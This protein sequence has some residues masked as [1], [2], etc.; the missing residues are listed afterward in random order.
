M[1]HSHYFREGRKV[2]TQAS[3]SREVKAFDESL[4]Q[5]GICPT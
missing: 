1:L 2:Y 4:L 5:F 3:V